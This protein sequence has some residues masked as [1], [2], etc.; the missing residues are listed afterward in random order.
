[1]MERGVNLAAIKKLKDN[2]DWYKLLWSC[3]KYLKYI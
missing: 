1:L 3:I 2:T